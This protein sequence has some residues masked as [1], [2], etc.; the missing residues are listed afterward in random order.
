MYMKLFGLSCS[1]VRTVWL[2]FHGRV[3]EWKEKRGP[4]YLLEHGVFPL[5]CKVL[6]YFSEEIYPNMKLFGW[7]CAT[8]QTIIWLSFHGGEKISLGFVLPLRKWSLSTSLQ[9]LSILLSSALSKCIWSCL[10]GLVQL[11][12]PS[13]YAFMGELVSGK[14]SLRREVILPLRKWSSSTSR[15]W[16]LSSTFGQ[17]ETDCCH[18]TQGSLNN[19]AFMSGTKSQ[20]FTRRSINMIVLMEKPCCLFSRGFWVNTK[21]SKFPLQTTKNFSYIATPRQQHVRAC[22][23]A[24]QQN[25]KMHK[26]KCGSPQLTKNQIGAI[27]PAGDVEWR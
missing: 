19:I 2:S 9:G 4:F 14:R 12:R 11:Y 16:G 22:K 25:C 5:H 15:E 26:C 23:I 10:G 6:A 24:K 1:T 3:G 21:Q 17:M 20:C 7:S 18:P 13:G 8:V 27:W